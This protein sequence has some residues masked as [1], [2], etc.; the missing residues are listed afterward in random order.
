MA[1]G[2]DDNIKIVNPGNKAIVTTGGVLIRNSW[3]TDWGEKG[4]GWL[5]YEYIRQGIA[6]DWWSMTKAEWVDTNK[7]GLKL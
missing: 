7:F 3:S 2:F 6:E 4:Y 1:V 5:P